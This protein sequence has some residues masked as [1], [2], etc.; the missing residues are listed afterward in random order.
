MQKQAAPPPL[1]QDRNASS[2][3]AAGRHTAT[4][5]Q[6]RPSPQSSCEFRCRTITWKATAALSVPLRRKR[7]PCS[8][9]MAAVSKHYAHASGNSKLQVARKRPSAVQVQ[10]ADACS[11]G[12]PPSDDAGAV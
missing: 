7:T 9:V 10:G 4:S 1:W 3:S 12:Q 6:G 5:S 8:N 2:P 11:Q